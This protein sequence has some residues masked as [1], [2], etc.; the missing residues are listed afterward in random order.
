LVV[1]NDK[2]LHTTAFAVH[3]Q[4]HSPSRGGVEIGTRSILGLNFRMNELTAA[5]G[6]VQLGKLD[7]IVDTLR[8]KRSKF[9]SLISGIKGFKFRELNDA[10]GDCATLCTVIFDTKE[11][12]AKASKLL[13]SKTLDK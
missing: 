13:E 10:E 6:L 1:T 9:K 4:G 2:D 3:D 12:A 7:K 11:Q 5:V 8:K